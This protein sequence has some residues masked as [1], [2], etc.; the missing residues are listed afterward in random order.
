[1][2]TD[3]EKPNMRLN[4]YGNTNEFEYSRMK[5]E[6]YQ[7]NP[8]KDGLNDEKKTLNT[9]PEFIR[10]SVVINILYKRLH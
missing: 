2:D 8:T 6:S 9:Y 10:L 4:S 3:H 5:I 1:M 7:I